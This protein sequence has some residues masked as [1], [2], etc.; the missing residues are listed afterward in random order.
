MDRPRFMTVQIFDCNALT[1]A[2][3]AR[4]VP[5]GQRAI[6]QVRCGFVRDPMTF[7]R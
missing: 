4:G 6:G 5:V 1:A 2:Q 7:A 3:E